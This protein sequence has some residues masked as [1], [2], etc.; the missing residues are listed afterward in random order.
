MDDLLRLGF[1]IVLLLVALSVAASYL[2]GPMSVVRKSGALKI[3]KRLMRGVWRAVF[4]LAGFLMGNR[5]RR[6]RRPPGS[7]SIG[8]FK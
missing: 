4:G 3:G 2:S 5:R 7:S 8:L 1:G 6:V